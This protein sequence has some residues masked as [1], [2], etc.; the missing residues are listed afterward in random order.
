MSRS[1]GAAGAAAPSMLTTVWIGMDPAIWSRS[2]VASGPSCPVGDA[3]ATSARNSAPTTGVFA[4]LAETDESE[5]FDRTELDLPE[6]VRR[7]HV[8]SS[9]LPAPHCPSALGQARQLNPSCLRTH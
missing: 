6:R 3:A 1:N 7:R 8:I 4:G 2:A 5:G 9:G